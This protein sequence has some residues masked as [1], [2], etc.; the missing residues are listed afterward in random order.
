[1]SKI[2][3]LVTQSGA[4]TSTWVAIPTGLVVDGKAGWSITNMEAYW[5]DGMSVAAVDYTVNGVLSTVNTATAFGD[6]DEIA[7]VSWGLQNTAGVAVAVPFEPIKKNQLF[8][9]RITV[10]PTIYVGIISQTSAQANDIIFVV[11]YDIVKLTDL[12]V[13]RMLAGGA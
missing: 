10:Q 13:L 5:V 9:P 2:N 8:E 4:D 7:R 1:M 12:E 6:D 3:Q 11:N